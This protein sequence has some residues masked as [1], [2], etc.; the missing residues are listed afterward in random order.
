MRGGGE[1][2][3]ALQ[4]T[5]PIPMSNADAM[6]GRLSRSLHSRFSQ[7]SQKR[8]LVHGCQCSLKIF[9]PQ[10]LQK[11]GRYI[12]P[13]G[14]TKPFNNFIADKASLACECPLTSARI[15]ETPLHFTARTFAN[16]RGS[17]RKFATANRSRSVEKQLHARFTRPTYVIR[18]P[19]SLVIC[20][21]SS[22]KGILGRS[23]IQT[24][25]Y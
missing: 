24:D 25:E 12:E 4:V 14:Q 17:A 19:R 5:K 8:P 16:A 20:Q 6:S 2:R 21:H 15:G 9:L 18:E 13:R 3:S 11:F 7:S 10:S 22:S 1:G 23:R